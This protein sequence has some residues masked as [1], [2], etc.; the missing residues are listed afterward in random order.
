MSPTCLTADL[1]ILLAPT[2][3]Q[4][5]RSSW[6]PSPTGLSR[7]SAHEHGTICRTTLHLSSHYVL[8]ISDWNLFTKFLLT[9]PWTNSL[10]LEDLSVICITQATL[11]ILDWLIDGRTKQEPPSQREQHTKWW[12]LPVL[13]SKRQGRRRQY[14]RSSRDY[15]KHH[16]TGSSV[17]D[18][19]SLC[20]SLMPTTSALTQKAFPMKGDHLQWKY[21]AQHITKLHMNRLDVDIHINTISDYLSSVSDACPKSINQAYSC[22]YQRQGGVLLE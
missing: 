15:Q 20:W 12:Y 9:I 8:P 13:E 21:T 17:S 4:S 19:R 7:L 6:Q 18:S 1:S 2:V 22:L 14:C 11:K 3:W 10:S 5:R 16:Q